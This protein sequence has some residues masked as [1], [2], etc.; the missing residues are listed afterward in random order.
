VN[1]EL[2]K[3]AQFLHWCCLWEKRN[4]SGNGAH[5]TINNGE[6]FERG[7]RVN[8]PGKFIPTDFDFFHAG[9]ALSGVS[10]V[11]LLLLIGVDVVALAI[12]FTN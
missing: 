11:V 7:C 1:Y 12:F 2:G 3:T 8:L 9:L 6:T 5:Q 4:N 10:R